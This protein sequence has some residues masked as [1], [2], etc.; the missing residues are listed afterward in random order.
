MKRGYVSRAGAGRKFYA[1]L[2]IGLGLVFPAV[3][4][5]LA[6]KGIFLLDANYRTKDASS[7]IY[8]L[9]SKVQKL[10]TSNDY[11]IATMAYL[12]RSNSLIS[13]KRQNA[14]QSLMGIGL[15]IMSIGLAFLL[16]SVDG[17]GIEGEGKFSEIG[18]Q[19]KIASSGVVIFLLG[20]GLAAGAGL[21]RYDY[22][23]V[24]QPGYQITDATVKPTRAEEE[25]ELM[26]LA[27]MCMQ[28]SDT[29]LES[30]R[31]MSQVLEIKTK[32]IKR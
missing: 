9:P 4:I 25:R 22:G 21:L 3:S 12:E 5:A 27:R 18:V 20:G 13:E 1:I 15:A 28:G 30:F 23:T 10:E 8:E 26:R 24:A 31:C 17:G 29:D 7:V 2:L 14:R 11:I 6:F 16:F 19:L 32:G